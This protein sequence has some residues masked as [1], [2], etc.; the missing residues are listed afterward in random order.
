MAAI[1]RPYVSEG[2]YRVIRHHMEFQW[3][4]YGALIGMPTDLRDRYVDEPWY[5]DAA[6]FADE[7]DQTSFDPSYDT[8]PLE[9]FEPLVRDIF[10]R[11]PDRENRTAM[12][13]L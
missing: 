12:D 10:G 8:F 2:G 5:A 11:T 9:H 7:F 13:C 1:A 3:Q 4:H 6:R